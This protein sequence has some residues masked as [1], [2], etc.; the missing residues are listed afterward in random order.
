[1]SETRTPASSATDT[2][3]S[4]RP[5][6]SP[7]EVSR[8]MMSR[9]GGRVG[10]SRNGSAKMSSV[11]PPPDWPGASGPSKH[12]TIW[13]AASGRAPCAT[14]TRPVRPNMAA[15]RRAV[16]SPKGPSPRTMGV[17][18][19]SSVASTLA[20]LTNDSDDGRASVAVRSR[21]SASSASVSWLTDAMPMASAASNAGMAWAHTDVREDTPLSAM[22]TCTPWA[23]AQT[24][25]SGESAAPTVTRNAPRRAAS[26]ARASVPAARPDWDTAMTTSRAPTQPGSDPDEQLWTGRAAAPRDTA[27]KRSATATEPPAAATTTP[28]GPTS[29]SRSRPASAEAA[30]VRRTWAP[31][32]ARARSVSLASRE[33]RARAAARRASSNTAPTG[34]SRRCGGRGR[35]AGRGRHPR[36]GRRGGTRRSAVRRSR[37]SWWSRWSRSCRPA[38]PSCARRRRARPCTAGTGGC[39]AATA[40]SSAGS[41]S[42]SVSCVL[43][44]GGP[45]LVARGGTRPDQ[46]E[47]LVAHVLHRL[48]VG[49]LDVEPQERLGV[50]GA[51]VE[52]PHRGVALGARDGEPVELVGA[53]AAPLGPGPYLLDDGGLVGHR[54]VDLAGCDVALV[55]AT[56]VGQRAV[57]LAEGGEDVHGG[58]HA[59][60]GVPEVAEVVVSRVLAAED[61]S[62]AGH[63]GLDERVADAG[64]H[65]RRVVLDD[66]LA[67][68][69]ARDDVV[70]DGHLGVAALAGAEDLADRDEPGDGAGR[71]GLAVGV[72]DEAAV[73]VTVEGEADVG[74]VL[75]HGGLEVDEVG[76]VEG[77]GLVVR[78]G[79]VELE[80]ERDDLEWQLGQPAARAEHGRHRVAAHAVAGVDDDLE[81]ARTGQVDEAAQEGGVVTEQIARRHRAGTPGRVRE[82]GPTVEQPLGEVADLGETRVLAHGAGRRPAQLDAVVLGRV[83][84]RREHGAGEVEGAAGV[85]EAVGRAE[86]DDGHVDA[87]RGHTGGEGRGELR[88]ARA[89]VV[90]DDDTAGPVR[91]GDDLGER[92]AEGV[93]HVGR[94]LVGHDST[95]VVGLDEVC[96]VGHAEHP[97]GQESLRMRRCPRRPDSTAPDSASAAA[98]P[99]DVVRVSPGRL[100]RGRPASRTASA[101][102]RRSSAARAGSGKSPP[103][104]TTSQP[105]GAVIRS[106]CSRHRS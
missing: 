42:R 68:R 106:A 17:D 74:T 62:G 63:L 88:R 8:S 31:A 26:A 52:P 22:G 12:A 15:A 46:G 101:R 76:G 71:D 95:Y 64:A 59:G 61:G 104:R 41:G 3:V 103:T 99:R 1:M 69:G 14:G 13:L 24:S 53:G 35:R 55:L 100:V 37:Q 28:R 58:E 16:T 10:P 77:V 84:A 105:R 50:G 11:P 7:G 25:A 66:D 90:A 73:G 39:R 23:R 18:S 56:E 48:T 94:E 81:R 92:G 65:R 60:V 98:W 29:R 5:C 49:G 21:T 38:H 79:A 47:Q 27:S 97:S 82:A 80:V 43:G 40:R 72:D 93:G 2:T 44:G 87:A 102:A 86:P 96:E 78:E 4:T 91:D 85:V 75:T 9:S 89:H 6:G 51:H 30:T 67:H 36:R 70:D 57:L 33:A 19:A 20:G 32:P 54:R 34:L 45:V 83:V